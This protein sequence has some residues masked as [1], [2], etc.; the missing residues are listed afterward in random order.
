MRVIRHPVLGLTPTKR[1]FALRR[2]ARLRLR[3]VVRLAELSMRRSC[4][5]SLRGA[6]SRCN[7]PTRRNEARRSWP[8]GTS[9]PAIVRKA[10]CFWIFSF[11]SAIRRRSTVVCFWAAALFRDRGYR[12]TGWLAAV[13]R[14][15]AVAGRTFRLRGK[16]RPVGRAPRHGRRPLA[17]DRVLLCHDQI[18]LDRRG[19]VH[20]D[21]RARRLD[22]SPAGRSGHPHRRELSG[23]FQR[24]AGAAPLRNAISA[25]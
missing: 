12:K 24:E 23:P 11:R 4:D 14:L 5:R 21:R 16:H 3:A 17:R 1:A 13:D 19:T 2:V 22:L 20:P 6:S 7:W 10:D 8:R 18:F 9:R 25:V 15:A